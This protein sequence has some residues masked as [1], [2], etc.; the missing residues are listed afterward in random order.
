MDLTV[1]PAYQLDTGLDG[2]PAWFTTA[3]FVDPAVIC[4]G[5]RTAEQW[6]AQGTGDRLLM[7][8]G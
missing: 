7:Q 6:E 2:Q 4:D 1:Q 3:Y 5:G 8:V